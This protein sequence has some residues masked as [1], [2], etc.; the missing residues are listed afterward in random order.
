MGKTIFFDQS[1]WKNFYI[2]IWLVILKN[3]VAIPKDGS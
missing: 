2:L 1:L 3:I